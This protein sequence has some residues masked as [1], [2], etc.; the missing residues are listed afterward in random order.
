MSRDEKQ[1]GIL[2]MTLMFTIGFFSAFAAE[3]E[4]FKME[5]MKVRQ[6]SDKSV[7]HIGRQLK[8]LSKAPAN[9]D[10]QNSGGKNMFLN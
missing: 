1:C 6:N 7:L 5:K 2:Q 4:N 10:T 8:D 3:F 9:A